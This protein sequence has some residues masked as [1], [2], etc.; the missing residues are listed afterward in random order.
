VP[1]YAPRTSGTYEGAGLRSEVLSRPLL[2]YPDRGQDRLLEQPNQRL[3]RTLAP[4]PGTQILVRERVSMRGE[5]GMPEPMTIPYVG[6][7]LGS[8]KPPLDGSEKDEN[9]RA[10][11][12]CTA[13]SGR[14]ELDDGLLSEHE[15]ASEA[16]REQS[17]PPP[18]E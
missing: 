13:C 6:R 14:F 11:G 4:S 3:L 18:S 15:T 5:R 17:Q 16:E 10:T 8:A 2:T 12:L 7:C 9:G 1:R